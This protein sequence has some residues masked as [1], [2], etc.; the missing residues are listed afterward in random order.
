MV[1]QAEGGASQSSE[2]R[3]KRP[4]IYERQDQ[5][6]FLV[7]ASEPRLSPKLGAEEKEPFPT[8][9]PALLIQC[10]GH[11]LWMMVSFCVC[12]CV[13][14]LPSDV[15]SQ[16]HLWEKENLQ[17]QKGSRLT[18][19]QRRPCGHGPRQAESQVFLHPSWPHHQ[20]CDPEFL[21]YRE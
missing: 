11:C 8:S 3:A 16:Q 10:G 15:Y 14:L 20:Q 17:K 1:G 19:P 4:R 21:L 18:M 2:S 6:S 13:S 5:G 12:S 9:L 7:P